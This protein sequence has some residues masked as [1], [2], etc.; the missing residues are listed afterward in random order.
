MCKHFSEVLDNKEKLG[1]VFRSVALKYHTILHWETQ[2][3]P[4][5]GG[6]SAALNSLL[7]S[8]NSSKSPSENW[9][10]WF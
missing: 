6:G 3:L 8:E 9:E 4:K 7:P 2:K 1:E 5:E 10:S